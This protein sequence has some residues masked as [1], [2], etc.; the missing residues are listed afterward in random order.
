M[1]ITNFCKAFRMQL[2]AAEQNFH[3]VCTSVYKVVFTARKFPVQELVA[4]YCW[5]TYCGISL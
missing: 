4:K 5:S 3:V 1:P 2:Q